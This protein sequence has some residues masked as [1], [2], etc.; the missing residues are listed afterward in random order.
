MRFTSKD[1]YPP[2]LDTDLPEWRFVADLRSQFKM[3]SN[4]DVAKEL[5]SRGVLKTALYHDCES[6]CAYFYFK[7][8]AAADQFI[9]LLNAQPEIKNWKHPKYKAC[10]VVTKSDWRKLSKFLHKT[11]TTEQFAELK[12]LDITIQ[13]E[14]EFLIQ[15]D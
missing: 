10:F 14:E 4:D 2:A 3:I 5:T 7:T 1:L 8:K 15:P 6:S 13:A 11:L 9:T 12:A